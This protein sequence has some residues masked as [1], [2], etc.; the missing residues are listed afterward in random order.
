VL[1]ESL[2][3]FRPPTALITGGAGQD[4]LHL[5]ELL[6]AKGYRVLAMVRPGGSSEPR[7]QARLG[8]L[9]ADAGGRLEA[10]VGDLSDMA[11]LLR[12]LQQARPD[13]IYNLA[14]LS[15]V[16]R[17]FDLPL[18]TFDVNAAGVL[19]LLEAVRLAGLLPTVRFY[20]AS[21]AELFGMPERERLDETAPFRP[22]S[23]YGAA[24]L[25]AYWA[26]DGYRR[27][28][29]L[30]ASNGILFNHE[31]PLRGRDFV[32]RKV[33]RAA[34]AFA[35]GRRS[36]PLALGNLGAVRDWGHA[37]DHVEGI[38]RMVR[39]APGEDFVLATGEGR[40]VRHLAEAAF[41]AAGQ[42]IAWLGAGPDER[43]V[44]T[45][46]GRTR[47]V[48]DTALIRPTDPP[49]LVG[50]AG[51]ARDRLDWRPRKAFSDMIAEMV[52]A[53]MADMPGAGL[54]DAE[55]SAGRQIDAPADG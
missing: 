34:A 28:Y 20:Q 9:L 30:R 1:R 7:R 50:D 39:L 5:A 41:R 23:P 29:G 31:S 14:A 3:A 19:R 12:L 55:G 27:A 2:A 32:S 4:G 35:S 48:V 36:R 24:K 18:A 43:G 16:G 21:T 45:S 37:R 54:E 47:I 38:W 52:A 13:E 15:H 44:E 33:C 53:E 40:S 46:T 49:R 17:S 11:A 26:V 6:L 22:C 42:P 8:Q 10:R 51:A 25:A